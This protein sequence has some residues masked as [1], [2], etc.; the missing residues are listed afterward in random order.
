LSGQRPDAGDI[1]GALG[2]TDRAPG[3]QEIEGM[4]RFNTEV[5]SRQ[6]QLLIALGE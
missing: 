1:A 2:D 6:R 3:I 5:I 4:R